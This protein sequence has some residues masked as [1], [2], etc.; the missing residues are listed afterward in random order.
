MD[1]YMPEKLR[2]ETSQR[3]ENA[4]RWLLAA[5]PR[6]TE[7]RVF[8]LLGL[9]WANA[10]ETDLRAAAAEVLAQQR[11]DGGWAQIASRNSDAYSAGEALFALQTARGVR[12]SDPAYQRGRRF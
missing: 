11:P 6:T 8:R 9:G 3:I 5:E 12:V 10:S 1:L 7:D 4:R 2:A